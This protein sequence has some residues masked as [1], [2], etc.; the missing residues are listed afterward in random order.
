ML[1]QT[2]CLWARITSNKSLR[3]KSLLTLEH[4]WPLLLQG[5]VR[6]ADLRKFMQR[7]RALVLW[8]DILRAVNS[9]H[10]FFIKPTNRSLTPCRN[11]AVPNQIRDEKICPRWIWASSRRARCWPYPIPDI[12][13]SNSIRWHEA[14][15][16]RA[17]FVSKVMSRIRVSSSLILFSLYYQFSRYPFWSQQQQ[18]S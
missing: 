14:L 11:P 13:G 5:M 1:R 2:R 18:T 9:M 3:G 10:C 12:Y 6:Q 8:R 7:Q 16:R 15:Y 17:G 4:V